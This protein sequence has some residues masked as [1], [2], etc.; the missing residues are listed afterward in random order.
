LTTLGP[1]VTPA[2]AWEGPDVGDWDRADPVKVA[3]EEEVNRTVR[4][5]GLKTTA[6]HD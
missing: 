3:L 2:V 5:L 4:S 6:C 1:G